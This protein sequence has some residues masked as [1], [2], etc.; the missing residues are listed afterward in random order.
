MA[1]GSIDPAEDHRHQVGREKA[2]VVAIAKHYR[3]PQTVGNDTVAD[4]FNFNSHTTS[5][6]AKLRMNV[7]SEITHEPFMLFEFMKINSN[8]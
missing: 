5:E 6:Y 7:I 2:A 3:Y 1:D 8:D 4:N